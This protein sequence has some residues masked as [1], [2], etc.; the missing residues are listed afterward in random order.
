MYPAT[1][2]PYCPAA[3]EWGYNPFQHFSTSRQQ[4]YGAGTYAFSLSRLP[5]P[6]LILSQC[7]TVS[8]KLNLFQ[9][10]ATD[11]ALSAMPPLRPFQR[12]L[13]VHFKFFRRP[14]SN[15]V[16]GKSTTPKYMFLALV[17]ARRDSIFRPA[18]DVHGAASTSF[19]LSGPL[20]LCTSTSNFNHVSGI[21]EAAIR[22]LS[23]THFL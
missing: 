5:P 1:D 9:G 20:R 12:R 22:E 7:I 16:A 2:A 15:A 6:Q 21:G 17:L 8:S 4:G 3:S 13:Q 18:R 10:R 23:N 14:A 11:P 19:D